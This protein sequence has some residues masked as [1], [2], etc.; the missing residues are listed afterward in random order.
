MLRNK[1]SAWDLVPDVSWSAGRHVEQSAIRN[2]P[3]SR[4]AASANAR[5]CST[6]RGDDLPTELVGFCEPSVSA[7]RWASL[8]VWRAC[9]SFLSGCVQQS[10]ARQAVQLT[11]RRGRLGVGWFPGDDVIGMVQALEDQ[12]GQ[13]PVHDAVYHP[14]AF[15]AGGDQAGEPQFGQMLADG[16][17]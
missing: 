16:G 15:F 8:L 2:C 13:V 4:H 5:W 17:P 12:T 11:G 7:R 3:L 14:A 10:Y 9:P 6:G 1:R